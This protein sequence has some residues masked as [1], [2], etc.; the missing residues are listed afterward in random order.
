MKRKDARTPTND[1]EKKKRIRKLRA[2][3]DD[4]THLSGWGRTIR[5]A[6]F[7]VTAIGKFS[8]III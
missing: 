3:V 8:K 1:V 2:N 6:F 7:A 4:R 5:V